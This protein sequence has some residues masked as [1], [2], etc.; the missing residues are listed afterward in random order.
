MVTTVVLLPEV[1]IDRYCRNKRIINECTAKNLVIKNATSRVAG[2]VQKEQKAVPMQKNLAVR[3]IIVC[4]DLVSSQP[5][6]NGTT[7]SKVM[8]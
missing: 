5:R 4:V 3:F 2:A 1:S 7:T 6:N 8:N